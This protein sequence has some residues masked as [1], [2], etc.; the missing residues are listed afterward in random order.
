MKE[1]GTDLHCNVKPITM[2]Q[3]HA[4]CLGCHCH[5]GDVHARLSRTEDENVLANAELGGLL[6]LR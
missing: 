6:E 1:G 3:Y 2:T 4:V 5:V